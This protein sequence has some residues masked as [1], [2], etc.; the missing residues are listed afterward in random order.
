MTAMN[1]GSRAAADRRRTRLRRTVCAAVASAAALLCA[2]PAA[3]DEAT[4]RKNLA[5]RLPNFPPIDEVRP[6]PIAGLFEIRIGTDVLYTDSQGHH[7]FQGQI[8]DT[9]TRENL[10]VARINKLTAIDFAT[11][12][13]KDAMVVTQGSGARK[14]AVFADPNCGFCKRFERDLAGLKDVTIYTFLYPLLGPDSTAKSRDIWCAKDPM[15]AWRDWMLDGALPPK[16]A[17][18]CDAGALDRNLA[19]GQRA[20]VNGTPATVFEDGTRVPGAVSIAQIEQR[21]AAASRA[22]P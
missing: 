19:L 8:I 17:G 15:K 16:A 6:M 2:A 3:A 18:A 13:L 12:P 9:R 21:L 7:V 1:I 4:I 20:R 5:E 11:L 22:K 14:M 10:T